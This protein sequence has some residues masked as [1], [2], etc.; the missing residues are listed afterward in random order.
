MKSGISEKKQNIGF[1]SY[2]YAIG[3]VLVVLGHSTPTGKSDLPIVIDNIRTF[4]YC[5]HMPLFFFI[6]GVLLKYTTSLRG[7]KPYGEFIK[8]KAMKFLTPYFV[9]SAVGIIPKLLLAD[10]VNDDVSVSWRYFIEVI[11]NPRLNVWGHFWFMPTLLIMYI[12]SYI[13]LVLNKSKIIYGLVLISTVVLAVF[14]IN[15]QWFGL[16]DFSLQFIY[17]CMGIAL[18]DFLIKKRENF[19]SLPVALITACIALFVFVFTA[20][21]GLWIYPVIRSSSSLVIALL[22]LYSVLTIACVFEKTGCK[23]LD[24]LNGK[25]FT[26]YLLSWPVQAAIEVLFNRVLHLPWFVTLLV[27]F[28]A[29]LFIPMLIITIYSRS[30]KKY[31]F[32]NLLIGC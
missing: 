21:D 27:M 28:G 8:G 22:M 29:G 16:N 18:S 24:Y 32:I 1:I 3:A 13:L 19:F 20:I 2:A 10:F 14:P 31:R 7:I 23:F 25:T 15:T 4:I 5:F 12:V 26:I 30:S 11:F 17:F 6:A 9:L